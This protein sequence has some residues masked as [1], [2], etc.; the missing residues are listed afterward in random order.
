MNVADVT[1][2]SLCGE[3]NFLKRELF[4]QWERVKIDCKMLKITEELK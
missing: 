1:I 3:L 2:G 4:F